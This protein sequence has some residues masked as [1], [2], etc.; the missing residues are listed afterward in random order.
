[1]IQIHERYSVWCICLQHAG[2]VRNGYMFPWEEALA[3][4]GIPEVRDVGL[5]KSSK[6]VAQ[7]Q[8]AAQPIVHN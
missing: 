2:G 3:D 6:C 4:T 1:M 8:A 5:T 7:L